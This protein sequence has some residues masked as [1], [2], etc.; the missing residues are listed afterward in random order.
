VPEKRCEPKQ[1]ESH[2]VN[3]LLGCKLLEL[4]R[5]NGVVLGKEE[6]RSKS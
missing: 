5:Q 6:K 3:A 1:V 2:Y 4:I